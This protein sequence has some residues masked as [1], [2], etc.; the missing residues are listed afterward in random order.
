MNT[1][2]ETQLS[3]DLRQIIAGHPVGVD[4]DAAI[5]RGRKARRRRVALRCASGLGMLALAAG[6]VVIGTRGAPGTITPRAG[7]SGTAIRAGAPG[8]AAQT[9]TPRPQAEP[10]AYVIQHAEAALANVS[11]YIIRDNVSSP[12]NGDDYVMWTDP[13]TGNSYLEQGTGAAKLAAWGSTYLV[14]N[15]MHWR[16]VQVN[17]G[18]RTWWD[19]VTSAGGP[20]QG[21]PPSGP[22]GGAGGTPADLKR[23][24]ASGR[25]K[26]IG[27][28]EI[29]GHAATG[30][31]GPFAEGY[32]EIWVDSVTF[33]PL[34]VIRAD[35]ANT[36]T[37]LRNAVTVTTE[38]WL[39]RASALVT[40]VNHP[41]IPSGFTQ[42]AVPQ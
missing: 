38:T 24:L 18:P 31:K 28:R 33:Q 34:Q 25:Y 39:P 9:G 3:D 29:D 12:W 21:A 22:Y 2:Q 15:V 36:H 27:H 35:F 20:I 17:Y 40:L 41:Q 16:T 4:I 13:R 1:Q 37:P 42:V 32:L 5:R 26:I 7:A 10:V 11:Q 14:N 30:L 19:S 23:L 6:A 8:P